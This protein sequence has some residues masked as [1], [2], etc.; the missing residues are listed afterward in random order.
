M[1]RFIRRLLVAPWVLVSLFALTASPAAAFQPQPEFET[2]SGKFVL[3]NC[4]GGVRLTEIFTLEIRSDFFVDASGNLTG[5]LRHFDFHGI[6]T[7]TRSGNTYQDNAHFNAAGDFATSIVRVSG[8]NF[9]ITVPGSGIVVHET[10]AIRFIGP[11]PA[12]PSNIF[13]EGGPHPVSNGTFDFTSLC[14]VLI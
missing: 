5:D 1:Q 11:P 14:S 6:I 10:G 3:A 4:G 12:D 13:F 7:N 2:D 8:E 9:A